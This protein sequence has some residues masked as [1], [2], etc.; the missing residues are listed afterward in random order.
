MRSWVVKT[1]FLTVVA[2]VLGG[3]GQSS[4]PKPNPNAVFQVTVI[5]ASLSL[6]AGEVASLTPSATN[7]SGT[8][9]T[10]TFTF[11]TSNPQLV[12][13]GNV[14]GQ[15]LVCGGVWDSLF[16]TCK[17][18]DSAGNPLAGTATVTASAAGVSSSPIQVTV[19][20]AV[21]SIVVDGPPAG[22]CFSVKQTFPFKAHACSTQV[23]PH[24]ST[25]PCAPNAKEITSSVGGIGW[26]VS[27]SN[28]ASVDTN[29]LATANA[30]GLTG[31]IASVGTVASPATNFKSC[32]P[33]SIVLHLNGDAAGSPTESQSLAAQ[34]T[35]TI[36][37]DMTDENGVTTNTAP[38]S[39][40][41]NNSIV[42][43]VSG[44]TLTA[45]TPGG[46]GLMATC[47]PPTCGV[48]LNIPIYSNVF[49]LT[50][51]GTSPNT[52]FIYTTSSFQAP[53]SATIL[54]IDSSKT[55]PAAGTA[56]NLPGTPNSL[57]FAPNGA[58]AYLG[59]TAGL[60]ALD[61]TVT[62]N[63]VTLL[64][65]TVGKVLAVSP[66]STTL[67][68]SNAATDPST[69]Q[70][71]EPAGPNQRLMIFNVGNNTVQ[72]FVLP[73]AVA[74]A[75]TGDGFK[76]FIAA[77]CSHNTTPVTPCP[78]LSAGANGYV[79]SP[80]LS[81]Q[82]INVS[83]PGGSNIDVAAL[84]SGPF[85]YYANG[86]SPST[87][88]IV[89][90]GTCNNTPQPSLHSLTTP[91]INSTNIQMVKA[92]KNAN[93]IVAVD[94]PAP[95]AAVP[96]GIDIVTATVGSLTPPIT[97]ANCAPPMTYSNQFID[98][99][100]GAFTAH[101]LVVPTNGT[102]G[103][104]GSHILVLPAGMPNVLV[105]TPGGSGTVIPLKGSGATEPLSGGLTLD[106]NTAWVGVAGSNTVDQLTLT[107]ST[108]SLQIATSF[109]KSDGTAAPPDIVAI[110]PK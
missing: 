94:S 35:S 56:I 50:V 90:V 96:A 93:L 107:S 95:P 100:Q 60:A 37:A 42:G 27:N 84:A 17:G 1:G 83:S 48:G 3:C 81:L 51:T 38:V 101:Q 73:G 24:D 13:V 61:T 74:A 103:S 80:S 15:V 2:A 36:E 11:N 20:P 69:G 18:T 82:T 5:P 108:D 70:P 4:A 53:G 65:P 78:G 85:G 58:K 62:P 88:D 109:K 21:S 106:G 39:I 63:T 43:S 52:T 45:N 23:T 59:T 44:T 54:P 32:L 64:D 26:T 40:L 29:G 46:A 47:I 87:T 6:V 9:I 110:K 97:T 89:P 76:A 92:P 12:T 7:S 28:V 33:V 25:G 14:Q 66:D 57:V 102:G 104:N 91:A 22:T 16:I 105:A 41:S 19:H 34:G 67:I 98:F 68:V 86:A 30:P 8:T 77:D 79:F 49:G 99:G 75:F 10:T 71:I 72:R 55:P 31:V